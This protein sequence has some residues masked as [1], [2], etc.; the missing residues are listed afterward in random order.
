MILTRATVLAIATAIFQSLEARGEGIRRG[1]SDGD[2][3]ATS[4]DDSDGGDEFD[5]V[6][7]HDWGAPLEGDPSLITG[8]CTPWGGGG[9][10]LCRDY[11]S[12]SVCAGVDDKFYVKSSGGTSEHDPEWVPTRDYMAHLCRNEPLCKGFTWR[13]G[14]GRGKLKSIMTGLWRDP[15]YECHQH[16]VG[17]GSSLL[18][19]TID[20]YC[21]PW[22]GSGGDLC[23]DHPSL[24]VCTAVDQKFYHTIPSPWIPDRY[25]MMQL[26]AKEPL[27]KGFTWRKSDGRGKLKSTVTG[28]WQDPD[29]ECHQKTYE[30]ETPWTSP[31][32]VAWTD[33]EVALSE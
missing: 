19:T 6:P 10:D 17:W 3:I 30:G 27:C 5:W 7:P 18:P 8:Y 11:P 4:I 26:C 25:D 16:E 13:K 14:D 2:G 33:D 22:G 15:N 29:Y 21:T 24:S 31:T 20:G 23:R 9:G 12:L 28:L 32:E 1:R